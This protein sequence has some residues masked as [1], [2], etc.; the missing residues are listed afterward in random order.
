MANVGGIVN[1]IAGSLDSMVQV[2][3]GFSSSTRSQQQL[4]SLC[5]SNIGISRVVHRR[6]KLAKAECGVHFTFTGA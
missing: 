1:G 5:T 6:E 4:G 2:A 3:V